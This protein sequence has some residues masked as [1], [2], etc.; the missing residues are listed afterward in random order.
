ME[1]IIK[2]VDKLLD[3]DATSNKQDLNN[4]LIL[5]F[6][7]DYPFCS[8]GVYFFCGKMGSGKTYGVI[9]H[10]MIT[11]RLTSK[12]Y[13]DQ[14]IVSSTSGAS[15]KTAT[16][17]MKECKSPVKTVSDEYLIPFLKKNVRQKQKYYAIMKLINSNLTNITDEMK[18]IIQK[19]HLMESGGKFNLRRLSSYILSK[20]H[21]YPFRKCPSNTIIILDDYGGKPILNKADSELANM[22]TKVRH[23]HYTFVILCQTWRFICLNLKRLCTDFIIFQGYSINDFQNMVEQSGAS[24]DWK[25]LWEEYKNLI[26]PRSYMCL[27]IVA[28]KVE[29]KNIEW[30][31]RT[32]LN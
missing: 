19:H 26:S 16:T 1:N 15:D 7:N 22:I 12:P 27:H 2:E 25:L 29:F 24:E 23:Y 8:N 6:T 28:N 14:I 30:S 10:I 32:L 18:R 3:K 9:R 21:K 4:A 13:Y 11:D 5:P 17:F 20:L 31:K